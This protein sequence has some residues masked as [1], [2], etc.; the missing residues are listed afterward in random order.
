MSAD[1]IFS[2]PDFSNV[3]ECK[4]R[5]EA[6][7][8]VQLQDTLLRV[9]LEELN[10]MEAHLGPLFPEF[11]SYI[12]LLHE[13]PAA[14]KAWKSRPLRK[15]FTRTKGESTRSAE[16]F[17]LGGT[18]Y[19]V[20]DLTPDILNAVTK[21]NEMDILSGVST[22]R[23]QQEVVHPAEHLV[24]TISKIKVRWE[25]QVHTYTLHLFR[26]CLV[27]S[28]IRN[29]TMKI[30]RIVKLKQM[31]ISE[32]KDISGFGH[33]EKEDNAFLGSWLGLDLG[34]EFLHRVIFCCPNKDTRVHW[35]ILLQRHAHLAR[36]K[37]PARPGPIK[38]YFKRTDSSLT[39]PGDN[40]WQ[41]MSCQELQV[42]PVST[43]ST[44]IEEA[45]AACKMKTNVYSLTFII[46]ENTRIM[47]EEQLIWM[48]MPLLIQTELKAKLPDPKNL[49]MIYVLQENGSTTCSQSAP[50]TRLST[51]RTFFSRSWSSSQSYH[52]AAPAPPTLLLTPATATSNTLFGVPLTEAMSQDTEVLPAPLFDLIVYLY[53]NCYNCEGIF[54]VPGS[55]V[56]QRAME[57]RIEAG[58]LV[59]WSVEELQDKFY[60]P[61][62]AS[63]LFKCYLRSLP[64]GLVP[65][66][67]FPQL[68]TWREESEKGQDLQ[69]SVSKMR[70]VLAGVPP[71][72]RTLLK[73][74]LYTL[75]RITDFST[76]NLMSMEVLSTCIGPSIVTWPEDAQALSILADQYRRHTPTVVVRFLVEHVR[77]VL[78]GIPP[79]LEKRKV[80][81]EDVRSRASRL[82]EV[83][84]SDDE[85][86][87]SVWQLMRTS[88]KEHS[89]GQ[90]S[91]GDNLLR[92]RCASNP[93]PMR[94]RNKAVSPG[95]RMS[96][97][98][99]SSNSL[100]NYGNH[101][102]II[103]SGDTGP[104][105]EEDLANS[106]LFL[107]GTLV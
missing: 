87:A 2:H 23:K 41:G 52:S 20:E 13:E 17:E 47:Y 76:V 75:R 56:V 25:N 61:N 95:S 104:P 48:E 98:S 42:K 26:E 43:V 12:L 27:F 86:T 58:E 53:N 46:L 91:S 106:E 5:V 94:V 24:A 107:G 89:G 82:E 32:Y 4:K 7:L 28:K 15:S 3:M 102:V 69:E 33:V 30:S 37:G 71:A 10:K 63:S 81:E 83:D 67:L 72:N 50:S 40:R 85:D 70:E 35:C 68:E 92:P 77:E 96:V 19:E 55:L 36:H 74:T 80:V 11:S 90:G 38:V 101:H 88:I 105:E 6:L 100:G 34:T 1:F 51:V 16:K 84:S 78:G 8:P 31:W 22:P 65:R 59:D 103:R 45:V 54:R 57:A 97:G 60:M 44:V 93:P 99:P 14:A 66:L 79:S 9:Q 21:Q 18:K 73:Y 29:K 39:V 64:G 62:V 49:Q